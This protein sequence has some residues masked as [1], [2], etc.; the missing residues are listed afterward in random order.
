MDDSTERPNLSVFLQTVVTDWGTR[1]TGI[2]SL[3]ATIIGMFADPAYAKV[4]W[5]AGGVTCALWTAY[6]V[7]SKERKRV[8]ELHGRPEV[9]LESVDIPIARN[10]VMKTLQLTNPSAYP[11]MNV[12]LAAIRVEERDGNSIEIE[13]LPLSE[14]AKE[15]KTVECVIHGTGGLSRKDLLACLKL[16]RRVTLYGT[17]RGTFQTAVQFSN[18][19]D[20]NRWEIQYALECDFTAGLILCRPGICTNLRV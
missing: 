7:W 1:I 15:A 19:G 12:T 20:A 4:L 11:A 2:A 5:V 9:L 8:I 10:S 6:Q 18:Y 14:V 13:F 17:L 3:P 16:D